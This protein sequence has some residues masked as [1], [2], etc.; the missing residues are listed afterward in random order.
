MR[1]LTVVFGLIFQPLMRHLLIP[2]VTFSL[3]TSS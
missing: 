2:C 1:L 3:I